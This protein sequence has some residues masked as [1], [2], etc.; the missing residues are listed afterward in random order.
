MSHIDATSA[1]FQQDVLDASKDTLIF[2]DFW[3]PWCGPCRAIA[4]ILEEISTDPAYTGKLQI[5]K[6]NVDEHGDLAEKYE[7]LGIPNMKFF[8]N[9]AVVGEV[10]G[11]KPKPEIVAAI[12]EQLAFSG[13]IE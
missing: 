2:V 9:G 6:V 11:M 13:S 12:D 5:V 10:T 1:S 7:I 3:A 8:R 4:P